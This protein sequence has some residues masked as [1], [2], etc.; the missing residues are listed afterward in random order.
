LQLTQEAQLHLLRL[1]ELIQQHLS[2]QQQQ[3]QQEANK[4]ANNGSRLENLCRSNFAC[5]Q[6][7]CR[8]MVSAEHGVMWCTQHGRQQGS[9]AAPTGAQQTHTSSYSSAA[10]V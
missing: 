1:Y 9:A 5:S 7:C 6:A 10:A 3:Q 8:T 4:Q 2:Q